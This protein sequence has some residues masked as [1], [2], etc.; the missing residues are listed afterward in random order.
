MTIE[1]MSITQQEEYELA[2][3]KLSEAENCQF[4]VLKTSTGINKE[5]LAFLRVTADFK[6]RFSTEDGFTVRFNTDKQESEHVE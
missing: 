1:G 6:H 2:R 5:Y 4:R 3:Y